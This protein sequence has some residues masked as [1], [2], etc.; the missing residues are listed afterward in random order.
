MK[1]RDSRKTEENTSYA[2]F[3]ITSLQVDRTKLS[4]DFRA[5]DGTTIHHT[6]GSKKYMVKE[7]SQ[8]GQNRRQCGKA[9]NVACGGLWHARNTMYLP[10]RR[11]REQIL[12]ETRPPHSFV[13]RIL[14]SNRV[15]VSKPLRAAVTRSAS[16]RH[17]CRRDLV[18]PKKSYEL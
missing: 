3:W 6:L 17:P 16:A 8:L 10:A 14:E 12:T 2:D 1:R 5:G 15:K 13:T 11:K 4:G 7:T 18:P 9:A